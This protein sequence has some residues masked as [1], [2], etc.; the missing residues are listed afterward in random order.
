MTGGDELPRKRSHADRSEGGDDPVNIVDG[1]ASP[2]KRCRGEDSEGPGSPPYDELLYREGA[3]EPRLYTS[4]SGRVW[5]VESLPSSSS[6]PEITLSPQEGGLAYRPSFSAV[7]QQRYPPEN[8]FE[9]LSQSSGMG[10]YSESLEFDNEYDEEEEEEED[11][12][13]RIAEEEEE[14]DSARRALS[15]SE[16]DDLG[17][18]G[19]EPTSGADDMASQAE[20]GDGVISYPIDPDT[21]AFLPSRASCTI[22]SP[23][24]DSDGFAPQED[25]P[26][27]CREGQRLD[28]ALLRAI[29][30]HV[31]EGEHAS[32]S[33]CAS[34][35]G[36]GG[37]GG[38]DDGD[39]DEEED[40][41]DD[42][43]SSDEYDDDDG[44]DEGDEEGEGGNR[45]DE[46]FPAGED[47]DGQENAGGEARDD[48]FSS[49][50][51]SYD[52]FNYR[53]G[54]T[55]DF[56]NG[57][58]RLQPMR[59]PRCPRGDEESAGSRL[60]QRLLMASSEDISE[61]IDAF[62]VMAFEQRLENRF[63][64]EC[65]TPCARAMR[66]RAAEWS[67]DAQVAHSSDDHGAEEAEC[68]DDDYLMGDGYD[69][70][71]GAGEGSARRSSSALYS[72]SH[73]VGGGHGNA[74]PMQAYQHMQMWARGTSQ[75]S[76]MQLSHNQGTRAVPID[77][78]WFVEEARQFMAEWENE[79][80]DPSDCPLCRYASTY[81][82]TCD[83]NAS[84][85][86]FVLSAA[87]S[88]STTSV[89][90]RCRQ[91]AKRWNDDRSRE[92]LSPGELAK[93][94]VTPAHI[95]M[96]FYAQKSCVD[97]PFVGI[98]HGIHRINILIDALLR[99][100]MRQVISDQA[101]VGPPV[102]DLRVSDAIVKYTKECTQMQEA[103]VKAADSTNTQLLLTAALAAKRRTT[104]EI[105][106]R[107]TIGMSR[108][109]NILRTAI[110]AELVEE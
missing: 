57:R 26:R 102:V 73:N 1:G 94:W 2:P 19:E 29:D 107:A 10:A 35:G 20:C 89:L 66:Q 80:F 86:A 92:G 106:K 43:G 88:I 75:V 74:A 60:A 58:A 4:S 68:G 97:W 40:D 93:R 9:P 96:H 78:P 21:A 17:W 98:Q 105:Q 37:G 67:P 85:N 79:P 44:F 87:I 12:C 64:D 33:F 110:Y 108:S 46:D 48:V 25:A 82:P 104:K 69:H 27:S 32:G 13:L 109:T 23:P 47:H 90:I 59:L 56:L 15:E 11:D 95:Y 84:I 3:P 103:A 76:A 50:T 83:N 24:R 54:T 42:R 99:N 38:G 41:Y 18:R 77:V 7:G 36:G 100:A 30:A 71:G 22:G 31:G 34:G 49:Y 45:Y 72:S 65:F 70:P 6:V 81:G 101:P 53:A 14:S 16:E 5:E 55:V 51:G 91:L 52:P 28:Q 39:D 61:V 63:S 8:D 62:G